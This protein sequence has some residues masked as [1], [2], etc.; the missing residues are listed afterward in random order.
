MENNLEEKQARAL[1]R[2]V[3]ITKTLLS[4]EIGALVVGIILT[5]IVYNVNH[6]FLSL[7]N[8]LAIL[9]NC[10]FIGV[11]AIGQALIVMSGEMDLS[12]GNCSAFST[13]V[14]GWLSIWEG[15]PWYVG[16]LAGLLFAVLIGFLNGLLMLQFGVMKWVATLATSNLC[17]G[18]AAYIA[19]GL[20]IG[21][22]PDSMINFAKITVLD[23]LFGGKGLSI[24]FICFLIMV[25]IAEL[26]VR[27]TSI[28]RKIQA[29]G[30]NSDSAYMAGVNVK[31]VKWITL[32]FVSLLAYIGGLLCTCNNSVVVPGGLAGADFKT[33]AACYIGGVGFVGSAGSIIGLF[34]GV[35]LIQLVENAMSSLG[36]DP[37]AQL[38]FLGALVMFVLILDVFKRRYMA[39]RIELI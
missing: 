5:I 33:V 12:V 6:S 3:R 39:S 14:F 20:P 18:L 23:G 37:N 32:I 10:S 28:G 25:I 15:L 19:R 27:Y 17:A 16:A 8:I 36:W 1:R 29:C 7:N 38:C 30:I 22:I 21:P 2:R 11:L 4:P 13:I 9:K 26:V 24:F 35:I 31:K 34:F